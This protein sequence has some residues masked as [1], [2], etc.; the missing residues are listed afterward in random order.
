V[1][2]ILTG[3][4]IGVVSFAVGMPG[5]FQGLFNI[6]LGLF[7][8]YIVSAIVFVSVSLMTQHDHGING[9][10]DWSGSR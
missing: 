2:A 10:R 8:A 4:A 9:T 7:V 3:G 5:P 6:D 1:A